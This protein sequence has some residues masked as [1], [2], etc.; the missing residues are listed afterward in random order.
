MK[1]EKGT[2]KIERENLK[3]SELTKR[4]RTKLYMNERLQKF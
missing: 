4:T 1:N 2:R 3:K